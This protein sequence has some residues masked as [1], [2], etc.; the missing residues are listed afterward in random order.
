MSN[1]LIYVCVLRC[2][3]CPGLTTWRILS[4][5]ASYPSL[6]SWVRRMTSMPSCS[7]YEPP[8]TTRPL[9]QARTSPSQPDHTHQPTEKAKTL[10][11]Y[12]HSVCGVSILDTL[13]GVFNVWPLNCVF[14]RLSTAPTVLLL[15]MLAGA[16]KLLF[17]KQSNKHNAKWLTLFS[18]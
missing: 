15:S 13:G 17:W 2:L 12:T 9:W 16:A 14:G 4:C 18:F 5:W 1:V 10:L 7:S 8:D 6:R 11:T 3:W